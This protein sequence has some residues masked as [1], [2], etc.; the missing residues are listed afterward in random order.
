[1]RKDLHNIIAMSHYFPDF[2]EMALR[3]GCRIAERIWYDKNYKEIVD[4]SG[5][6]AIVCLITDTTAFIANI[7]DSRAIISK[8]GGHVIEQLSK[9]HKPSELEEQKRIK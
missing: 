8:G 7:G 6:C 9:D 2:P 5:S 1:M 3:E 4:K